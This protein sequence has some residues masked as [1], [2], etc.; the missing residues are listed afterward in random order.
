MEGILR[1]PTKEPYGGVPGIDRFWWFYLDEAEKL[2]KTMT[3]SWKGDTDGI[4]IFVNILLSLVHLQY[5]TMA[6]CRL[7]FSLP[8]LARSSSRVTNSSNQTPVTAL[9]PCWNN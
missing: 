5:L 6:T 1:S 3:D 8:P 9:W 2:D 4:L 7:V